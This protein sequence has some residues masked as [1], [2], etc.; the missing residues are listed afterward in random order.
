[1]GGFVW[2]GGCGIVEPGDFGVGSSASF[3]SL[4]SSGAEGGFA[5]LSSSE[6]EDYG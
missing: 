5:L 1:M 4:G 6:E 3:G 2:R